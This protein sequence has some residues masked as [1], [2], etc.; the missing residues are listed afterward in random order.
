MQRAL[1]YALRAAGVRWQWSRERE[2]RVN[3]GFRGCEGRKKP[4]DDAV[5]STSGWRRA[6]PRSG[7]I[8]VNAAA[9]REPLPFF[10]PERAP[11]SSHHSTFR[12][13]IISCTRALGF[14]Y[15]SR[16]R[17]TPAGFGT[18]LRADPARSAA[19]FCAVHSFPYH[20]HCIVRSAP[21]LR[22]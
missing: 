15:H 22:H 19:D 10:F 20:F 13:R 17:G 3:S 4:Q 18:A 6:L 12:R 7:V 8:L 16:S 21:S 11:S 9:V 1:I 2:P 5:R 14:S